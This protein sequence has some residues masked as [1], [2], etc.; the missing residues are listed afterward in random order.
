MHG[1]EWRAAAGR[2]GQGRKPTGFTLVLPKRSHT[3]AAQGGIKV[4]LSDMT[5]V[6]WRWHA[7]DTIVG[8]DWPGDREAKLHLGRP[9]LEVI[10]ELDSFGLPFSRTP[11][12]K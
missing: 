4:A 9:A 10:L 7:S 11:E 3:G 8:A 1:L 6:D 12:G 5:E 2:A